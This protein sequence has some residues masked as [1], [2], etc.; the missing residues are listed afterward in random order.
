MVRDN[1]LA[2]AGLL[3]PKIGGPSVKPYQPD[4]L[5]GEPELPARDYVGGHGREPV[6][7]RAVHLVAAVVPA[8]EPAG[9]RRPQPRGMRGGPQPFEHPAAGLVL[10]NDPTYVEAARV[11]AARIL[12]EGGGDT[13]P[14]LTW[15]WRRPGRVPRGPTKSKRSPRVLEKHRAQFATRR[16]GRRAVIE[17]RPGP[18]SAGT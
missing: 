3:V 14:R 5:L 2:I 11:F 16:Q 1:A 18:R 10:L 17:N 12:K 15:A 4:G 8:P 9:L 13:A 7:P 6:P